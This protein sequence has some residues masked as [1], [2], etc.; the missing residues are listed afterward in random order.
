MKN[1]RKKE[2]KT[3]GKRQSFGK[4]KEEMKTLPEGFETVYIDGN[5]LLYDIQLI[6]S[7]ALQ[8]NKSRAE[9]ALQL[10]AQ[11]WAKLTKCNVTLIFD[12]TELFLNA[13]GFC[14]CSAR[15]FFNTSDLA[16]INMCSFN[17]ESASKLVFT[18]D[19][20]L[21]IKLEELGVTLLKS[22]H[23]FQIASNM[24]GKQEGETLDSW[25]ERWLKDK[26]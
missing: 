26:F 13:D 11:Q 7:L 15:P 23:F 5:E 21:S 14:V 16:L 2:P 12:E 6:R 25:T 4:F 17:N 10:I 20:E 9:L 24:L 18:S 8:R 1:K 19:K 22:K 3:E